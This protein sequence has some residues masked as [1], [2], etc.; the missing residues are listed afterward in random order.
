MKVPLQLQRE[1]ALEEQQQRPHSSFD[2]RLATH[3][4]RAKV[5]ASVQINSSESLLVVELTLRQQTKGKQNQSRFT[6][7][8]IN[9]HSSAFLSNSEF[10]E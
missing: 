8:Q 10:S 4:D 7:P 6:S 1:A 3:L 2:W 5:W 9:T